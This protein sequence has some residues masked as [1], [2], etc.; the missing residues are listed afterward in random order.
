[1]KMILIEETQPTEDE[2]ELR[3]KKYKL[4]IKD[5]RRNAPIKDKDTSK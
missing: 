3:I 5:K 4:L 2:F 1:M